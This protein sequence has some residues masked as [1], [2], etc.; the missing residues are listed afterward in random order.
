[1]E[2][3][4]L[5][6]GV[7][8]LSSG[9]SYVMRWLL[10]PM[11]E[12][13]PLVLRCCWDEWRKYVHNFAQSPLLPSGFEELPCFR[14]LPLDVGPPSIL[15]ARA[16]T[17]LQLRYERAI[18]PLV[19]APGPVGAAGA[20]GRCRRYPINER[21]ASSCRCAACL[22]WI[23]RSRS[24]DASRSTCLTVTGFAG[25]MTSARPWRSYSQMCS[26]CSL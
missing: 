12:M 5:V 6:W 15:I 11:F 1:M 10:S 14:S 23:Y 26:R 4:P 13:P 22:P 19:G 24:L 7:P 18:A 20:G 25:A 2:K 21:I 16:A 3:P 8:Y 17:H 9:V